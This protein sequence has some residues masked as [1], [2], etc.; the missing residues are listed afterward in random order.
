MQQHFY[1]Q[2]KQL[3]VVTAKSFF[4]RDTA[5]SRKNKNWVFGFGDPDYDHDNYS[6]VHL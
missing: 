1:K 4:P 2:Y 5:L 3:H 6:Y